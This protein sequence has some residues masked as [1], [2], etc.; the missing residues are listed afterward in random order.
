[1]EKQKKGLIS[2][3]LGLALVVSSL[4]GI[5][6][7]TPTTN[8]HAAGGYHGKVIIYDYYAGG[9][10]TVGNQV[11]WSN[12]YIVL[13]NISDKEIS[14]AD[15]SLQYISSGSTSVG[16]VMY[17]FPAGAKITPGGYVF[18]ADCSPKNW[19]KV[20][21]PD[22]VKNKEKVTVFNAGFSFGGN[23]AVLLSSSSEKYEGTSYITSLPTGSTYDNYI[24]D[25][26]GTRKEKDDTG[27]TS[28]LGATA[29]VVSGEHL[30]RSRGNHASDYETTSDYVPNNA[31]DYTAKANDAHSLDYLIEE[32]KPFVS[33]AS[34]LQLN[35]GDTATIKATITHIDGNIYTLQ[36]SSAGIR[37]QVTATEPLTYAVDGD[38]IYATG[39]IALDS[40]DEKILQVTVGENNENFTNDAD[41]S[42][43]D[44][45]YVTISDIL[46]KDLLLNCRVQLDNAMFNS[47]ANTLAQGANTIAVSGL[48]GDSATYNV[49][50]IVRNIAGTKTLVVDSSSEFVMYGYNRLDE[51]RSLTT[52]N[53]LGVQ[54][55][56]TLVNGN[57][58]FI[59][60]QTNGLY[61]YYAGT[62]KINSGDYVMLSG[63]LGR[64]N[65]NIQL[66]NTALLE[67]VASPTTAQPS[68]TAIDGTTNLNTLMHRS[69][70]IDK[71][72]VANRHGDTNIEITV[73]SA[74]WNMLIGNN[75]D[76][77]AGD[78]ISVKRAVVYTKEYSNTDGTHIETRLYCLNDTNYFVKTTNN[79]KDALATA[80]AGAETSIRGTYTAKVDNNNIIIQSNSQGVIVNCT[81]SNLITSISE[82]KVVS[83]TGTFTELS[84]GTMGVS[85]TS[86]TTATT[87]TSD[88][89]AQDVTSSDLVTNSANYPLVY[90]NITTPLVVT[91]LNTD[92]Y[93]TLS[94]GTNEFRAY[95]AYNAEY[96]LYDYVTI[97]GAYTTSDGHNDIYVSTQNDVY[98][99]NK[100]IADIYTLTTEQRKQ[101]VIVRGTVTYIEVDRHEDTD[102][103][104][105]ENVIIQQTISGVTHAIN[106]YF[107]NTM[108]EASALALGD[109]VTF[110]GMYKD[111]HGLI[112]LIDCKILGDKVSGVRL[113]PTALNI[114]QLNETDARKN[115]ESLYVQIDN[116][117]VQNIVLDGNN[118][119]MVELSQQDATRTYTL[120]LY[121]LEQPAD[122]TLSEDERKEKIRQYLIASDIYTGDTLSLKGFIG[123]YKNNNAGGFRVFT[124][125]EPNEYV[126]AKTA[127]QY[128]VRFF[129]SQDDM[130]S[131]V[132]EVATLTSVRYQRATA[133]SALYSEGKK[134][135]KWVSNYG[136]EIEAGKPFT[137][138]NQAD[139][140]YF[141]YYETATYSVTF[142][143]GTSQNIQPVE[144]E[145]GKTLTSIP[146]PAKRDGYVFG[147]W[148]TTSDF[149]ENSAFR[150]DSIVTEDTTLYAKWI[151]TGSSAKDGVTLTTPLIIVIAIGSVM[152]VAAI[153]VVVV[154]VVRNKK[155]K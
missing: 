23:G 154:Y 155:N 129:K 52:G 61:V 37:V 83:V 139:V 43:V 7:H 144:V 117:V 1:M 56:A 50:A 42:V 19:S 96:K 125:G 6:F 11:L 57:Y 95:L 27:S 79:V 34:A 100:N 80:V 152:V 81:D 87:A 153:A 47:T 142:S 114:S 107:S 70:S 26:I 148:Y 116:A 2:L 67:K 146:V 55:Y 108:P 101:L 54:G 123:Y 122:K 44:Y 78:E 63:T 136:D 118:N 134:F 64:D 14:I 5:N 71:A 77:L 91:A 60:D 84:N 9:Q 121:G 94:D 133:P 124:V 74:T 138:T 93:Y 85:A 151:S 92:G 10:K 48:T 106:L 141:A 13:K 143:T 109:T 149:K 128:T 45:Q 65:G 59:E 24:V 15:W 105:I 132:N 41:K 29:T 90:V 21:F 76:L 33:I 72:V 119:V 32:Q 46:T 18:F 39:T 126:T 28:Y 73:G 82:G 31:A 97:K 4:C 53:R 68:I 16:N 147:G 120:D 98:L 69:V 40:N 89:Q 130:E 103:Y 111:F 135:V 112:E 113:E 88:A 8:V 49:T 58:L 86:I 25:F 110:S 3:I 104:G 17:T 30:V 62:N 150:S 140:R 66:Q 145:F 22:F 38:M 131:G 20:S 12:K 36:D 115:Y 127:A 137:I 102:P 99:L 35:V 51:V 75:R